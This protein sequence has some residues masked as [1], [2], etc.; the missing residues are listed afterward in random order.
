[1]SMDLDEPQFTTQ[2]MLACIPELNHETYKQWLKRGTLH[3]ITSVGRGK[4]PLFPGMD[5]LQVATAA[6]LT[7]NG[8]ITLNKLVFLWPVVRG[9]ALAWM[10]GYRGGEAV[11]ILYIDPTTGELG[12]VPVIEDA[13]PPEAA[14]DAPSVPDMLTMF[15]VDRFI[16]RMVTRMER[17]KAGLPAEE[18]PAPPETGEFAHDEQGRRVLVGLSLAETHELVALLRDDDELTADQAARRDELDARHMAARIYR[19]MRRPP[20][21]DEMLAWDTDRDGN[22]A[23]VG[24]T[25]EETDE[26]ARLTAKNMASRGATKCWLWSSW[27]EQ[28]AAEKR[29]GVLRKKHDKARMKRLAEMQSSR[30]KI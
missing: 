4:R 19:E 16:G 14:L 6:E 1:M 15:R 3:L 10:T 18:P 29:E 9:R 13:E 28:D 22:K 20:E 8:A 25:A 12:V 24:L 27:D 2:E 23:M 5:V 7:R 26:L 17:V 21:H 11:L 30:K